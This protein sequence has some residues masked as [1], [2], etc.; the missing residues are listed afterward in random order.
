MLPSSPALLGPAVKTLT[1]LQLR[2]A[3]RPRRALHRPSSACRAQ[4][5]R[6]NLAYEVHSER[7]LNSTMVAARHDIHLHAE[8][9]H[10]SS[11][12]SAGVSAGRAESLLVA[13]WLAATA[14]HELVVQMLDG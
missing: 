9:L 13:A 4:P 1:L 6:A 11:W 8:T 12:A 3:V 7:A 10:E 5:K 2:S 14:S